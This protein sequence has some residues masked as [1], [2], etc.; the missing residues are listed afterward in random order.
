LRSVKLSLARILSRAN[1]VFAHDVVMTAASF[2]IALWLRIGDL[3]YVPTDWLYFATAV[4]TLIAGVVFRASNLY[5][6]VWRYASLNDLF[7]ITRAATL[8]LLIFVVLMFTI[9]RLETLPRSLP[10][11]NWFVLIAL[12]GGPRFAYRFA[13]DRSIDFTFRSEG[14]RQRVPVLLVGAGDAAELFIRDVNRGQTNY[15]VTGMVSGSQTRVGRHIHNVDILGTIE[16]IPTVVEKLKR[17]GNAPQKL[18]LTSERMTRAEV[19][20]LLDVAESLGMTL[21]RLGSLTD[22]RASAADSVAVKP[23]DVEDLLFRPQTPLDR[24]AMRRLVEG[25]TVL[26]TGAGG[27]IGGELVRQLAA[28]RPSHVTLVDHSEYNLFKIDRELGALAPDIRRDAML[29]D[30]RDTSRMQAVFDYTKPEIVFHAAAL[31]HVPMVEANV[32]EGLATNVFGTINVADAARAVGT[33]VLVQIS[34]DKAVNPSSI[35]GVSK[36]MAEMYCQ[37]LD[38]AGAGP[39]CFV[40]VRF[41]NVLGSTGSV[42]ELFRQQ[43]AAGGPLTVTDPNMTR[44]FMTVRE[45]VELVL[46]ASAMGADKPDGSGGIYVLDMGEPVRIMDLARQMIRLAGFEPGRDIEIEIIGARPGE[47]LFEEVLH[48][49]ENLEPT[50]QQG[51]LF[52]HPR[53]VEL[54]ALRAELQRLKTACME[55]NELAARSVIRILV[56][57]YAPP[58]PSIASVAE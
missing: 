43:L 22:F 8:S 44:Y 48:G 10:L 31:K 38:L 15:T 14:D 27:S 28:F 52:A 57:E 41:G 19:Q 23:I 58:Q 32:L 34:T 29:A 17:R 11:I 16:D 36:R 3:D 13:K 51:L 33:R 53:S 49:T 47:K 24:G 25:R 35:M 37:A 45:A 9:T 42:V 5:R 26:V 50:L 30:V 46:M 54:P 4:F 7:A 40:T 21:A 18:I 20:Q 1:L 39:T 12:L 2:V 55:R 56:P 6:G